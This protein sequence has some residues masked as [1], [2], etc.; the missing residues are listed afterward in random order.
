[1]SCV[2]VRAEREGEAAGGQGGD[3]GGRREGGVRGDTEQAGHDDHA[4]RRGGR[5]D[6]GGPAEPGAPK[7]IGR[8]AL[9]QVE[10]REQ[11]KKHAMRRL[12]CVQTSACSCNEFMTTTTLS[13]TT[14]AFKTFL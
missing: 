9:S 10:H 14:S 8:V 6:Y 11:R 4:G 5:G 12:F 13:N 3:A 1:M 7:A 2:V